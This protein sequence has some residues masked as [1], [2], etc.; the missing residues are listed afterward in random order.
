MVWQRYLAI[1]VGS[2]ARSLS[3]VVAVFLLGLA[4]GYHFFGRLTEKQAHRDRYSLMKFYGY[5]EALIALYAILF[6]SFFGFFKTVSFN[7]P[8]YLAFDFLISLGVLFLPTFLMGA[9]IPLLTMLVPENTKEVS[10]CHAKI[11]AGT[12]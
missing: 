12:L 7:A 11:T 2:E 1:L 4:T 5:M 10:L 8:N 6:P 9:S 3:L